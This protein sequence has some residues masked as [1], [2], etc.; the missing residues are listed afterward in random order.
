MDPIAGDFTLHWWLVAAE[1]AGVAMVACALAAA[2][3]SA[4]SNRSEFRPRPGRSRARL[5]AYR[6]YPVGIAVLIL[7]ARPWL[8]ESKSDALLIAAMVLL[9]FGVPIVAPLVVRRVGYIVARF[10]TVPTLLA[11]RRLGWDPIRNA[12][13]HIAAATLVALTL[14]VLGYQRLTD[15]EIRPTRSPAVAFLTI[16]LGVTTE[17]EVAELTGQ[18][19][20]ALV[21]V[22]REDANR[23]IVGASCQQ[24]SPHVAG[25]RCDP[26]NPDQ[27]DA[28]GGS[29]M[30]RA[31]GLPPQLDLALAPNLRLDQPWAGSAP[32]GP[33][34][35]A[36][37]V[38][39]ATET[40][41]ALEERVGAI[42]T[43]S[44]PGSNV[45]GAS[46]FRGYYPPAWSWAV[47][48]LALAAAILAV[49]T[50]LPILD[51]LTASRKQRRHLIRIGV[52]EHRLQVLEGLLF[53]IPFFV[54]VAV[55]LGAGITSCWLLVSQS[56]SPATMPW[57]P[58]G[59]VVGVALILGLLGSLAVATLGVRSASLDRTD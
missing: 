5:E 56:G 48:G 7:L 11:G 29:R 22:L 10:R 26:N 44:L 8:S 15:A 17:A 38:I 16:D 27:F 2:A 1:F 40:A 31:L 55:G 36:L 45:I 53:G 46:R 34:R 41:A 59:V 12:R 21:A 35:D 24:I 57:T 58:I 28:T 14:T 51:Q 37:L 23:W 33:S 13:P 54:V 19:R 49:G 3:P 30:A 52:T 39:D 18:L 50:V 47:A 6:L 25:A 20:P 42:T 43:V 4:I 32:T 9:L